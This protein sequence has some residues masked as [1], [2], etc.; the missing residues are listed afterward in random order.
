MLK[1]T[2]SM[3]IGLKFLTTLIRCISAVSFHK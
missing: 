2:L 1:R 3:A